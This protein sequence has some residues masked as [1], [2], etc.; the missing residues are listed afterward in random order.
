MEPAGNHRSRTGLL[1]YALIATAFVAVDDRARADIIVVSGF[2]PVDALQFGH[3]VDLTAAGS[4]GAYTFVGWNAGA[5]VIHATAMPDNEQFIRAGSV[6]DPPLAEAGEYF[7][8]SDRW[9]SYTT[10]WTAPTSTAY[11]GFRLTLGSGDI[12]YGWI[13]FV[14]EDESITVSRWAYETESGVGIVAGAT[15][16]PV[17]GPVGLVG[18]AAGAA[19]VRRHRGRNA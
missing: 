1:N 10:A 19:G 8:T 9:S 11:A 17:P 2:E 16:S 18:L 6:G 12:R 3:E 7:G 14:V 15:G 5:G 4:G 13:E